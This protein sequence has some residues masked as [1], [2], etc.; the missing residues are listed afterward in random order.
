MKLIFYSVHGILLEYCC[1][2]KLDRMEWSNTVRRVLLLAR[3][4]KLQGYLKY[5][6]SKSKIA[7]GNGANLLF[8][9]MYFSTIFSH[10]FGLKNQNN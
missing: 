9:K 5:F 7:L 1:S 2:M 6:Y 3:T 10:A 8:A 4:Y